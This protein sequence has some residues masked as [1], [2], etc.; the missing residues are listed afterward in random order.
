[1]AI[2]V[3]GGLITSTILTLVLVPTAY[4]L[5]EGGLARLAAGR[6]AQRGPGRATCGAEGG[7]GDGRG[8]EG[9]LALGQLTKRQPVSSAASRPAKSLK[10][11]TPSSGPARIA[12]LPPP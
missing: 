7:G 2:T 9:G 10:A 4:S 8:V 1:M 6:Q 11:W 5:V 3:I 12:D